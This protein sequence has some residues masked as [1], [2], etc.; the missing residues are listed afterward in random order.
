MCGIA[1]FAGA[2][3][4]ADLERMAGMLAHRGPDSEAFWSEPDGSVQLAHRRL[5]VVDLADGSQPMW[6]SDERLGVVFNGEIYNHAELREELEGL[7][8]R[9]TTGHSDTEVLLHAY[10]QWGD[11]LVGRLEGMW[12]FAFY[13]RP[14]RRIFLSRDRF[15]EKPLYWTRAPGLFAFASEAT[16]LLA[17]SEVSTG[18][19]PA[20]VR[21]YFAYGY[22]PA[23]HSIYSG[24]HKLPAGHNL[25]VTL[26]GGEPQLKTYWEF[27]LE[28]EAAP[29]GGPPAWEEELRE[30]LLCSVARRLEADVPVGIFLSGG[31]DSAGITAAAALQA[32]PGSLH[33]FSV[34]F[35]EPSFDESAA[36]RRVARLFGAEHH[37][38]LF[39]AEHAARVWPVLATKLD[40][41]LGDASLLPTYVLCAAARRRVTVAL[42]GDGA[43]ELFAG[44]DPFRALRWAEA[45]ARCVP[46]PVHRALCLLAAKFPVSHSNLS[47]GFKVKR[48]LAGLDGAPSL[49]NPLWLA[50][51]APHEVAELLEEP[52]TPE[53]LY[54]EAIDAWDSAAGLSIVDRTLQFYTRTYL[55]NDILTKVD[56]ASMLRG[57]EVRSPYLDGQIVDLVRRLPASVK[58]RGGETKW[59]LKRALEP[60]LPADVRLRPKK[61][62]GVPVGRW[63]Q[64]GRAPMNAPPGGAFQA[65]RL[66]EHRAGR[67]D[68]RLYLYA[69]WA[70]TRFAGA[71]RG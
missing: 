28:P 50:P 43:D 56:R 60:W 61:G 69:D 53:E 9:F 7:G 12:A 68:H 38:Y 39:T 64:Q 6:T 51:L 59:L 46:R 29:P 10:R 4:R 35:D 13:D 16:A 19:D 40:E 45:Y 63:L 17:H 15:G 20:A 30:R 2:G 66:A 5:A 42:G 3:E 41:P 32:E 23:P 21:K 62:F 25:S 27:V 57:L 11:S 36:A 8:H 26:P 58:L 70:L 37:P 49:W 44:Y 47:L 18:I 67:A 33:T 52:V 48:A 24:V 71:Q 14:A 65:R 31:I 54:S 55:Q 22:V 34:G 1:G